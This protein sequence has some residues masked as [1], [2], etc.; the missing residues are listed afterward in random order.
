[1]PDFTHTIGIDWSGARGTRHQGLAVAICDSNGVV[2]II[3]PAMGEKA[4]SRMELAATLKQKF[5]HQGLDL[6]PDARLLVGIDS[7]FGL[8]FMDQGSY[9][10]ALD[11]E[12]AP[13]VWQHIETICPLDADYYAGGFVARYKDYL[14]LPFIGKGKQY[15]RRL[16][17]TEKLCIERKMGP[18]ESVYHLI[19][20]S[21]VGMSAFSAMRMLNWL[22]GQ[23]HI[24]VWPFDSVDDSAIVITEIYAALFAQLGGHRGKVKTHAQLDAILDSL[25]ASFHGVVDVKNDH[26]MDAIV[27]AAGLR[28]IANMPKYWKPK[29][30]SAKIAATEGWIFGVD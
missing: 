4:W 28:A 19:G 9:L 16:R 20:P 15:D 26:M 23:D 21:Q 25:G 10:P 13:A 7:A 17:V 30:L 5:S 14:H 18:C 6:G 2:R 29:A 1:M 22:R 12:T 3:D 8:P 27:T 24:T 11:C